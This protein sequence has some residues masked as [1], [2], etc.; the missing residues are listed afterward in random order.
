MAPVAIRLAFE[1]VWEP[2]D[3]V[4]NRALVQPL[5]GS[6]NADHTQ[7]VAEL[8]QTLLGQAVTDDAKEDVRKATLKAL[9][10]PKFVKALTNLAGHPLQTEGDADTLE[11]AINTVMSDRRGIGHALDTLLATQQSTGGAPVYTPSNAS[12]L[13]KASVVPNAADHRA[14]L[15]MGSRLDLLDRRENEKIARALERADHSR[16]LAMRDAEC[17]EQAFGARL[18]RSQFRRRHTSSASYDAQLD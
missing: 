13:P 6:D 1:N 12:K 9:N 11:K 3:L 4:K 17:V 15:L 8:V 7:E 2:K 18:A 10:D 16:A 5:I 14:S